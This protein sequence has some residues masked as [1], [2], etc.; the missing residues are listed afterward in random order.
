MARAPRDEMKQAPYSTP[1]VQRTTE[2]TVPPVDRY[3]PTSTLLLGVI[4]VIAILY[5]AVVGFGP[6]LSGFDTYTSFSRLDVWIAALKAGDLN[7]T[8]TSLDANGYGSPVPFFY[9]K[10]FNLLGAASALATGDVVVGFRFAVLIFSSIMFYGVYACAGRLGVDRTG[11]LVVAAACVLSPYALDN[12]VARCAVA[13]YAAMALIP[14]IL[15]IALDFYTGKAGTRTKRH[16]VTLFILLLLLALAHTL[17]F[18]FATGLLLLLALRLIVTSSAG[19]WSL[20]AATMAAAALFVVLVYVPFTYWAT[21]FC[22]AQAGVFGRPVDNIVAYWTL[23]APVPKSRSGWPGI[24]LIIALAIQ[25]RQPKQARGSLAFGLGLIALA[26]MLLMTP[27]SRPLWQLSTQLDFVQF[28]WRLLALSTPIC[29]VALAGMIER[30]SLPA[31]RRVQLGILV[32]A[33]V[34]AAGMLYLYNLHFVHIPLAQLRHE[35]PST[36]PGPDAAGEYFP[37]AFQARLL[38][39]HAPASTVL[40]ARRPFLEASDCSYPDIARP[41]YFDTLQISATCPDRGHLRV[42]QFA[43]PFLYSIATDDHGMNVQPLANSQIIEFALPAG[44]WTVLVRTR[45][46]MELVRMAWNTRFAKTGS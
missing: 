1:T 29:L 24:A 43:T 42:N 46:Y 14:F 8:W 36:G 5:L 37:A 30:L 10:L 11:R 32:V 9:H 40:P 33:F 41:A 28:P 25:L 20:F 44:H 12:V 18:V 15:A 2:P 39:L 4:G 27:L 21:Y 6:I 3:T 23:F 16:G 13:E 22:P 17:I 38:Q 31:K 7:S 26:L 45:S 34:N 19:C 35:A